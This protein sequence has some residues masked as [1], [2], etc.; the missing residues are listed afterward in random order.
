SEFAYFTIVNFFPNGAD[1][2]SPY[3]MC[4]MTS[5]N[6]DI[7][8]F[9]Y[10]RYATTKNVP[11]GRKGALAHRPL[12]PAMIDNE[13]NTLNVR[14]KLNPSDAAGIYFCSAFSEG[15]RKSTATTVFLKSNAKVR[16]VDGMVT[17]TVSLG[18]TGVSID[19]LLTTGNVGNIKW[20]QNDVFTDSTRDGQ[21]SYLFHHPIKSKDAGV[22]EC[23]L[24]GERNTGLT[25]IK[26]LIVRGCPV[27]RWNPPACL[28]IC[29]NC[30]NGGICGD[31]SGRCVCAPG[32][33]GPN[34]LLGCGGNS[35]GRDCEMQCNDTSTS[36][37]ACRG[38]LFCLP[39]PYGCS[40]GPGFKSL[41]CTQECDTGYYGA[42]CLQPCRCQSGTCDRFTGRCLPS[43]SVNSTACHDGWIGVTCQSTSS[44]PVNIEKPAIGHV[45][46]T[47][48]ADTTSPHTM[49]F[50]LGVL[51]VMVVFLI[52]QVGMFLVLRHH[53]KLL[54]RQSDNG[55]DAWNF[56]NKMQDE[57]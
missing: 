28:G 44:D 9:D 21:L 46:S 23:Y 26:R 2:D 29:D 32:F 57:I 43:D 8:R 25:M 11:A 33:S 15:G 10:N 1:Q 5:N 4:S 55:R 54:K 36:R 45:G 52:L 12:P 51:L 38:T 13:T 30:Y 19:V 53:D 31:I 41:N 24:S 56:T 20:R 35:F 27:N 18:D 6:A 42:G 17:R 39:D 37:D 40:C 47:S 34:C 48:P 16:P 3:Y 22:Y 49:M 50:V 7:P 14:V